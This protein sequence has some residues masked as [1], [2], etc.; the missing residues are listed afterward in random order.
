LPALSIRPIASGFGRDCEK[1]VG[2]GNCGR[3]LRS[4]EASPFGAAPSYLDKSKFPVLARMRSD[5][6]SALAPLPG[7]KRT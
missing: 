2:N 3:E 5:R 6:S 4:P 1:R 7:N